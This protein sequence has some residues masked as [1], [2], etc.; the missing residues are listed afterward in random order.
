MKMIVNIL[1]LL[2]FSMISL[3]ANSHTSE[4]NTKN[5][6]IKKQ[7]VEKLKSFAAPLSTFGLSGENKQENYWE[8]RRRQLP[9]QYGKADVDIM[10]KG[11][12]G[13]VVLNRKRHTIVYL[14][15]QKE[16]FWT[17]DFD[18]I[19]REKQYIID[20]IRYED[21]ILYFNAACL[22]YAKEQKGKCSTLYAYDTKQKTLLWHSKYLTS[23][24]IFIVTEQLLITGYGFTAEPDYL[25]VFRKKDGKVLKKIKLDSA[26]DY[27]EIKDNRLHVITYNKH[28]IFSLNHL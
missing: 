21:N 13:W 17:I 24:N 27:L 3:S 19:V 14:N 2:V 20:D 22:S 4:V 16:L 7:S 9:K 1:F 11:K 26:L 15:E 12:K 6:K 23:R 5:F 8:A 18:D 25:T 10:D 28:Y